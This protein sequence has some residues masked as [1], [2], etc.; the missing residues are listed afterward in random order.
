[1]P[2]EN[3]ERRRAGRWSPA[4]TEPLSRV[5]LRAGRELAVVNV[6]VHGVLVEGAMRLLPG[7]H[8]D[9]HIMGTHGRVL[10][11][12]RVVRCAVWALL[13]DLVHYR[14]ALSFDRAVELA[15]PATAPGA[16]VSSAA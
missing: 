9:V 11:R 13:A 12:A 2:T 16:G 8:V 3:G 6:S 4:L 5:R 10:V 14:G 7:T 1:M 15:R